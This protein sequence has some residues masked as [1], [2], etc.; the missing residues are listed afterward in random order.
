MAELY[1][2]ACLKCLGGL[3]KPGKDRHSDFSAMPGVRRGR[4]SRTHGD[5][6]YLDWADFGMKCWGMQLLVQTVNSK[7]VR[8]IC[9]LIYFELCMFACWFIWKVRCKL[10]FENTIPNL[11]IIMREILKAHEENSK[12]QH[13]PTRPKRTTICWR[14]RRVEHDIIKIKLWCRVVFLDGT[15]GYRCYRKRLHMFDK[16]WMSWLSQSWI[17]RGSRG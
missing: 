8:F 11:T 14:W 13:A 12:Q 5:E 17:S 1:V 10:I 9:M 4:D 6:M 3:F 15:R 7:K 2:K 16:R